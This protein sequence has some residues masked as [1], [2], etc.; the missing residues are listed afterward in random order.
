M[1]SPCD[2][3]VLNTQGLD[4]AQVTVLVNGDDLY[5]SS[6]RIDNHARF[7]KRVS[8]KYKEIKMSTRKVVYYIGM[9][10]DN[11]I[12]GQVSILMDNCERSMHS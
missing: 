1:P 12:P 11:T 8:N 2:P 5:I 10:Y 3:C 7:E 9:T 4:V 6:K